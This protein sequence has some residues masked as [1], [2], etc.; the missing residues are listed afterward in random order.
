M[1][2]LNLAI[3]S[4]APIAQLFVNV[5][6]DNPTQVPAACK[7][8]D[9]WTVQF[10]NGASTPPGNGLNLTFLAQGYKPFTCRMAMPPDNAQVEGG[11]VIE[12]EPSGL[13]F[14][15]SVETGGAPAV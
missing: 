9:R 6:D 10:D 8:F 7:F 5:F 4:A 2:Q 14:P 12:M 11:V 3:Q 15:P 1:R 13:P